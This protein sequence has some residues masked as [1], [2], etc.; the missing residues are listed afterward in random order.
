MAVKETRRVRYVEMQ[1]RDIKREI[2]RDIPW[3]TE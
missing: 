1:Y 3:L 2:T